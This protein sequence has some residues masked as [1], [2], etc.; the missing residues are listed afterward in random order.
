MCVKFD[1]II[2]DLYEAVE[3]KELFS[4]TLSKIVSHL[5]AA[6]SHLCLLGEGNSSIGL[7]FTANMDPEFL[8]EYHEH[9]VN[10]DYRLKLIARARVG[11]VLMDDQLNT[12]EGLRS[13]PIHNDLFPRYGVNRIMGSNISVDGGLGWFGV[14]SLRKDGT[15]SKEVLEDFSRL[16][17]HARKAL[18]LRQLRSEMAEREL[19]HRSANDSQTY[20]IIMLANGEIEYANQLARDMLDLGF[21]R[22]QNGRLVCRDPA[23]QK[24]VEAVHRRV[25]NGEAP[26]VRLLD[27]KSN[28]TYAVQVFNPLPRFIDGRLEPARW[29]TYKIVQLN[30]QDVLSSRTLERITQFYGLS[31]GE[32]ATIAAVIAMEPLAEFSRSKGVQQDTVRKQLKAAMTKM[33]VNSQKQLFQLYER[34]KIFE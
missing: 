6:Q 5:G 19:V 14:T 18:H 24:K 20:A 1:K 22:I 25:R 4:L 15:F 23:E 31:V 27:K 8:D 33:G 21:I 32:S 7:N 29:V 12:P 10:H 30:P 34:F 11:E 16:V 2:S 13:S 9:Y 3:S 28:S 26:L 17:V